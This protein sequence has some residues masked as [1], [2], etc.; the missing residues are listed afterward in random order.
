MS[1]NVL[2][3]SARRKARRLR[4]TAAIVLLSGI[5]GADLVYWLG[6]RSVDSPNPLPLAGEDKAETRRAEMLMG[7][8]TVLMDEWGRDLKRP[9]TQA[10]IVFVTAALAA[11]G[12]LYFARL[13]DQANATE[14]PPG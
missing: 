14:F 7:Q 2:V 6:T 1:A 13:H 12:C 5:F 8:Q 3:A 9:G 4:I 11:A 10:G